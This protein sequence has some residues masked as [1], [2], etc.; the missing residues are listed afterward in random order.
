M[1]TMP[2][3]RT[4]LLQLH[5]LAWTALVLV[6][7]LTS[8]AQ[9]PPEWESRDR[10]IAAR[11]APIFH[12]GLVSS[13]R[14]DYITNFDFDGDW[15]GDNNWV[16]AENQAFPLKAYVYY[17][18][19]ETPTHYFIHY[20]AFHPRD[21]KGGEVTGAL[22]SQ[23]VR[24]GAERA[25]EIRRTSIADEVVLAHEND[26]EGCLVI[27]EKRG[28]RLEDAYLVAVETL[29]HNRYLRYQREA[30]LFGDVGLVRVDDQH[31][32][33]YIEPKGH[34][35]EAFADQLAAPVP[36]TST[37]A[38]PT[39]PEPAGGLRGLAQRISGMVT[40]VDQTRRALNNE[41]AERIRVYR[42]TGTAED[43]DVVPDDIGYDLVPTYRTLW[44][45]ARTGLNPT[46]GSLSDYGT[47]AVNRVGPD[48]SES[49]VQVQFGEMGSAFRG[50]EGAVNMARPPW[51]WFDSSERDRPLGEWFLDPA[52]SATRRIELL[53]GAGASYLH[54]PF[55][56][57]FRP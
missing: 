18:V 52:G 9:E 20:A 54:Q 29:A 1:A 21:Y 33:I 11:F 43:P 36:A 47:R 27:A 28:P 4:A 50:V 22:L 19:S 55:L 34:G 53:R 48:G 37:S 14:F 12:Q 25:Q 46:Y 31:P 23:A 51:G 15:I 56:G 7:P 30:T 32:H 2:F 49:P 13:G 44:T 38:A 10:D 40:N 35:M 26:L 6:L 41:G 42:F 45:Q 8:Q 39:E 3:L 5:R 24:R 16:N 57:I 17:A